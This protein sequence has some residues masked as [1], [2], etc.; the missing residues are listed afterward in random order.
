MECAVPTYLKY[1]PEPFL[2]DIVQGRCLPFIGAGFSLN[3]KLPVG[4]EMPLWDS[5]GQTAAE[6]LPSYQYSTALDAISAYSHEFSRVKLIEFLAAVLHVGVAQPGRVHAAFCEL[7]FEQVVTTNFDFLLED[8][9]ASLNRYCLPIIGEEQLAVNGSRAGSRLLKLH[10]DLN[11]P[12]RLVATEEDYDGFL[13]RY[14]LLA[15]HL[16]SLLIENTALFIGYSLDDPDFRQVWQVVK[17]R[18]GELRRPAYVLQVDAPQHVATRYERRGAKVINLPKSKSQSYGS[19]LEATFKELRDY[20]PG[21]LL[22][23]STAT[24]TDSQAELSLPPDAHGRMCF[25]SVPTRMAPFYKS[26]VYPLAERCGLSPIMAVDVVSP[27]DNILAKVYAL[28]ERAEV[29]VSEVSSVNTTLELGMALG[30]GNGA[31]RLIAIVE[32]GSPVPSDLHGIEVLFRPQ[33]PADDTSGFLN[34]LRIR[35]A[36]IAE[37]LHPVL[38]DEPSRLLSKKEYRAAVISAFTYLENALRRALERKD[39]DAY[40]H[41][42]TM[43]RLLALAVEKGVVDRETGERVLQYVRLRNELVHTDARVTATRA[44]A[45]VVDTLKISK[46]LGSDE[47]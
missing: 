8:A 40:S 1:F 41:R 17:D 11:H 16:S 27:G 28:I 10:G 24:E 19:V 32:E 3:A 42:M 7:P 20:W 9:Y 12:Q 34:A 22:S 6:A 2:E 21:Q 26:R 18:L 13:A 25:F 36:A 15:T 31:R 4:R 44:K 5:L 37:R 35:F 47:G 23:R 33:L 46:A 38:G 39:I 43:G 29:V 30:K 14:P 45:V